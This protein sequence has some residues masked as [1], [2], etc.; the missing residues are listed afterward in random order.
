MQSLA[1]REAP[2]RRRSGHDDLPAEVQFGNPSC[3]RRCASAMALRRS[4]AR[5]SGRAAAH[6]PRPATA[7]A[8]SRRI[9]QSGRDRRRA[10]HDRHGSW[11][12][13]SVSRPGDRPRTMPGA[14][15][16]TTC[17]GR[18]SRTPELLFSGPAMLR[19]ALR[20]AAVRFESVIGDLQT[21]I[22]PSAYSV[23]PSSVVLHDLAD[24]AA[25]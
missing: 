4:S 5:S 9:V 15:H 22:A 3:V 12:S 25:A 14:W 24:P 2:L 17:R 1:R 10:V 6:Q 13:T 11:H 21:V 19:D 16:R 23:P 18:T 20:P 8:S 7:M